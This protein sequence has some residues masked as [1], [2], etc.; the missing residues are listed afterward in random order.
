M[1]LLFINACNFSSKKLLLG[2]RLMLPLRTVRYVP[3]FLVI[4]GNFLILRVGNI[5]P[6]LSNNDRL[7][8]LAAK[9]DFLRGNS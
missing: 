9:V 3:S 4:I 5:S 8:A 6:V 2:L 1:I 7:I